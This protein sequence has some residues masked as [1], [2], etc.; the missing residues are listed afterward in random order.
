METLNSTTQFTVQWI[1]SPCWTDYE[2]LPLLPMNL[3]ICWWQHCGEVKGVAQGQCLSSFFLHLNREIV[4]W[5]NSLFLCFLIWEI[6]TVSLIIV[7]MRGWG[8]D[9]RTMPGR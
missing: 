3:D 9:L 2:M 6:G 1:L 8:K 4:G 7:G 5:L